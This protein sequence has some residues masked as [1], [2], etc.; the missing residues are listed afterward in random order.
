MTLVSTELLAFLAATQFHFP[1]CL[2]CRLSLHFSLFPIFFYGPSQP[3]GF[4][5]FPELGVWELGVQV[6]GLSVL[7]FLPRARRPASPT[8]G[9]TFYLIPFVTWKARAAQPLS[10]TSLAFTQ[11]KLSKFSS[12]FQPYLVGV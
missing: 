7:V 10:K 11:R 3:L 5:P 12:S 6:T 1:E 8:S 4:V 2:L 9:P